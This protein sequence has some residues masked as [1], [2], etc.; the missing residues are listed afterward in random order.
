MS[1]TSK[2]KEVPRF[3][4]GNYDFSLPELPECPEVVK[5]GKFRELSHPVIG[6]KTPKF[7][8]LC[9]RGQ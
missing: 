6:P 9:E 7:A 1:I 8:Q 4:H 3:F 2:I 5:I